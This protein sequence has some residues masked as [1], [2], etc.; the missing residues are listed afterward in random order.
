MINIFN[1]G[2]GDSFLLSI[3]NQKVSDDTLLID[4]GNAKQNVYKKITKQ[5]TKV[6]ITHSDLDHI[7]GLENIIK[8][9]NITDL[10]IS[11]YIPEI[12]KIIE[13]IDK[14][15]K[16]KLNRLDE[17]LLKDINI[18]PLKDGDTIGNNI[19]IFSPP[20]KL[21]DLYKNTNQDKILVENAVDIINQTLNLNIDSVEVINYESNIL[22][23]IKDS[24]IKNEYAEYSRIF[25]YNQFISLGNIFLNKSSK[26]Y[27]SK[28]LLRKAYGKIKYNANR[29]SIV[30]QYN[31]GNISYLFTT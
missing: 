12:L 7:G 29:I 10:Y 5:L 22:K 4:C 21:E 15:T 8:H 26:Q 14:K 2:Q 18:I 6:L 11:Y 28:E 25:F 1:V 17:S 30:L 24:K 23:Y 19:T 3:N 13:Y 31:D 27:S 9:N 20:Q 16:K